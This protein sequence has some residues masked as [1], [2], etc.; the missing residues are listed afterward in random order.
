MEVLEVLI[1]EVGDGL[2]VAARIHAIG[3]VRIERLLAELRRSTAVGRRIG[4][5]H[6]V[7]HHA[8]DRPAALRA[9]EPRSA[10]LPGWKVSSVISGKNTASR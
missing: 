10:S 6:L 5:L 1:G 3:V 9:V 7:E 4:A 2:G 8:L